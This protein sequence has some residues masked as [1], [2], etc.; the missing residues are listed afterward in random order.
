MYGWLPKRTIR[1]GSLDCIT[2]IRLRPRW[3]FRISPFQIDTEALGGDRCVLRA[4]RIR[5]RPSPPRQKGEREN[6][7]QRR[8]KE[9]G[10]ALIAVLLV[11]LL[12]TV[13]MLG[14]YFLTTGEQ[15]VAAS[16]RDNAVAYYGAMGALEKMSSDL[17]AFFVTHSSPNPAQ[18]TALTGSS[19][20]PSAA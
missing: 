15:K 10:A 18:I 7:K 1:T 2:R 11:I 3:R 17:A 5:G 6:M 8:D 14:F 12:L 16:D 19:F 4:R 20:I 9:S 13:M